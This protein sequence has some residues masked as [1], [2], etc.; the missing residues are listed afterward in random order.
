MPD[1]SSRV[2]VLTTTGGDGGSG[3]AA[4]GRV[5]R[6]DRNSS[7]TISQYRDSSSLQR[8]MCEAT[9]DLWL[10]APSNSTATESRRAA[11]CPGQ[12]SEHTRR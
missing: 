7:S 11:M 12:S 6:R 10:R 3:A 1:S 8:R 4:T 5:Q 9:A 2:S